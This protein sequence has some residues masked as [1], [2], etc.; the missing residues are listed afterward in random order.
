VAPAVLWETE[1]TAKTF[2]ADFWNINNSLQHKS[3]KAAPKLVFSGIYATGGD[4]PPPKEKGRGM[5]CRGPE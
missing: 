3:A 1:T 2:Q 5:N 4:Q